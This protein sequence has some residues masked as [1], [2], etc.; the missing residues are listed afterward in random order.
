MIKKAILFSL[1]LFFFVPQLTAQSLRIGPQVGY[2]K[3]KD[4]EEGKYL[5]GA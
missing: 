3:A 5:F 2:H 4:A 1:I